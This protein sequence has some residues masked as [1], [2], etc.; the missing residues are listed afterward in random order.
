MQFENLNISEP[1]QRALIKEGYKTPTP[2]QAEAIPHLL[3]GED[4][5]GIAQTG[6]GKTAAFVLPVLQRMA[7]KEKVAAPGV[8]RA[9]VLAPT[10]EL[11]AQIDASFG[12]YGQFLRFRHAAV[13][14]GV[15]QG[16]QV[17]ALSRG[18]D[19]L[20]ATPGRLLDLMEQ[21]HINLKE[22]EFF[23]LDEADR[24]LDMGFANDVRK[25]VSALPKKR[26]S[27]FFAAT[28]SKEI[29]DLAGRL[30]IRP[31][32]IEVA[33]QA[34]TVESVEQRILFVDQNKKDALLLGLLQQKN[35]KRVLVFT[36]T[37]RRADKVASV[38][39]KNRIRSDSIHG[40]KSQ[41]QRTHA[42]NGFKSGR[43]QVLVATDIAARGI[44]VED[45][46]H[47]INYDL[48]N[49]AESYVHRIGRTG[50]AGATGTAYSFCAA[51]ERNFLRD[52]ERLTRGKIEEMDHR[53]HS[54]YAKNA[55]GSAAKPAPK[56]SRGMSRSARQEGV[57]RSGPRKARRPAGHR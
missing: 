12:T 56:R 53:Y 47:V 55:V 22:I 51:D 36:R 29:G 27:L 2:I 13:Y 34:T 15:N 6:T 17:R 7:E 4:L 14:G 39:S 8:P 31:V 57:S 24:M 35:L 54:E 26:H 41:N 45:I 43:L 19:A 28:M 52:I 48:P 40:N 16:P 50:R 25:I 37:K 3:K 11:A 42:L 5:M 21:G 33:P 49:E 23:V 1:L 18:V 30:L 44:D 32:R 20:V 10:R 9:L 46:S 38:L